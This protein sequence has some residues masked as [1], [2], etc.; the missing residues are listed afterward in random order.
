MLAFFFYKLSIRKSL[1]IAVPLMITFGIYMALRIAVVGISHFANPDILNFPFLYASPSEAFATKVYVL[2]KYLGLLVFPYPLSCD[3][4]YNQVPYIELASV[5]F[6]LSLIVIVSLVVYA[7]RPFKERSLASFCILY[8]FVTI[9]LF[10]NFIIDIGAPLA[11]RILFQPSLAFCIVLAAVFLAMYRINKTLSYSVLAIVPLLASIETITR[12]SDWKNNETL[13]SKDVITAPNSVRTNMYAA[14]ELI[15]KGKRETNPLIKKDCFSKAVGYDEKVISIYP[16][17][18]PIYIDL[19]T[20]YYSMNDYYKAAD[21][22]LQAYKLDKENPEAVKKIVA[23]SD[24]LYNEGNRCYRSGRIDSAITYYKK[25]VELNDSNVDAW[26]NMG[27][28][29][30]LLD[31]PGNGIIAWQNVIRLS[32]NHPLNRES[33]TRH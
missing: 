23:L 10:S 11:E 15:S 24:L 21:P 16:H 19:G 20:A 28:S 3:Y 31:N 12:N 33:F 26:Y 29:Y 4:G 6:V 18:L 25:S 17:Y 14:A 8:F 22:W 7:F 32:P 13:Y 30:F 1:L 2:L 9:F 27:G 5:P